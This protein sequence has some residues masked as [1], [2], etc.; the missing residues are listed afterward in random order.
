MKGVHYFMLL[1]GMSTL[2]REAEQSLSFD[3]SSGRSTEMTAMTSKPMRLPNGIWNFIK[4]LK[5]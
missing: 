1:S 2:Q 4:D 5:I 3:D